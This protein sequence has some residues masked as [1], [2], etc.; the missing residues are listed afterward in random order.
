MAQDVGTEDV[1]QT[2][3]SPRR[4]RRGPLPLIA[5]VLLAILIVWLVLQFLAALRTDSSSVTKTST[6]TIEVPVPTVPEP[7]LGPQDG[8]TEPAV[9]Q[10]TV[11]DVVGDSQSAAE[12]ELQDAGYVSKATF[13]YSDAAAAGIVVGQNPG[14]GSALEPGAVVGIVVSRGTYSTPMVTMPNVIGLSR[15]AAE[16]KV[17]AAGLKPYLLYGTSTKYPGLIASQWPPAGDTLPKGSEG[18]IQLSVVE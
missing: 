1:G 3:G 5:L 10:D 11:P 2:E 7:E 17:R 18:F 14:G 15:S 4:R 16:S 6:T 8:A 13:V 9:E 12:M